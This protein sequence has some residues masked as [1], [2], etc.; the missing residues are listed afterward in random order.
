MD[1]TPFGRYR[2]VELL[3]RGG[4]GEVWRAHDSGTDRV[5]A[6]KLLPRHF[7]QNSEF[8][9][10]F[11]REARAAA[12]LN[13]AHVVP[14]HDYGEINGQLYVDMRL[15]DGHDLQY[16]LKSGP[17]DPARAVTIIEQI[18]TA[19]NAAHRKGLV[20]RDVK[21]SNILLDEDDLAYLIDFGIARNASDAGLTVPGETIGTW[22]YMAPERFS[23]DEVDG[24][25][26]VYSLACVLYECLTG[27]RP[28]PGDNPGQ[29]VAGHMM[30]PP[31]RPS[32]ENAD[33]PTTFD[34]VIAAGL[35]K[36]PDHRYRSTKDLASAARTALTASASTPPPR[37][38]PLVAARQQARLGLEHLQ[39]AGSL[40]EFVRWELLD[41]LT[42]QLAALAEW[43]STEGVP[44]SE[45]SALTA[46]VAPPRAGAELDPRWN[47]TLRALEEF[48][49]GTGSA[50]PR[51]RAFWKHR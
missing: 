41:D 15:V 43:L 23:D 46:L 37:E 8:E 18:A 17:V 19:L 24:R 48:G 40:P 42:G 32:D 11:R 45:F 34:D 5:V 20:H 14:I 47:A 49:A 51:A 28:F 30:A 9:E 4:M 39:A 44:P 2:L 35:A 1:G 31:P 25:T 22:A 29:I 27:A 7:A 13:N 38:E 21:P 16:E 36:D 12:Q 10:R 33:V 3:G 50:Q 6:V 26:D